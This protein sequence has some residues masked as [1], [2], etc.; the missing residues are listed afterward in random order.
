M[1]PPEYIV[2]TATLAA[3]TLINNIKVRLGGERVAVKS[4]RVIK[5]F[6][7]PS[8]RSACVC[9]KEREASGARNVAL[10]FFPPLHHHHRRRYFFII[11]FFSTLVNVVF[12]W[13]GPRTR[14][15]HEKSPRRRRCVN[16]LAFHGLRGDPLKVVCG[17][18]Y[19]RLE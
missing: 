7:T 18:R 9:P 11:F 10:F 17:G 14:H 5:N 12:V 15:T 8:R 1:E 6:S 16:A 3:C 4:R 19:Y 2:W 13:R